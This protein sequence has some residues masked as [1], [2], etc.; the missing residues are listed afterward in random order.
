MDWIEFLIQLK[1]LGLIPVS[2]ITVVAIIKSL[3]HISKAVKAFVYDM[4]DSVDRVVDTY[5][6]V[7]AKFHS[8]KSRKK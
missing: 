1:T 3:P 8:I 2:F 7:D 4:C 5:D 6:G